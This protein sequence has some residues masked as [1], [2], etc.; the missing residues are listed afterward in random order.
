VSRA[1]A[2]QAYTLMLARLLEA[3]AEHLT[4]REL[5]TLHEIAIEQLARHIEARRLR[6]TE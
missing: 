1:T 6:E 2:L 3:A 4:A 5:K